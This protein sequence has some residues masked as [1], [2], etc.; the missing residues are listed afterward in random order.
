MQHNIGHKKFNIYTMALGYH[1]DDDLINEYNET[2]CA[3]TGIWH[4]VLLDEENLLEGNDVKSFIE[5]LKKFSK[6][7]SKCSNYKCIYAFDLGANIS[8]VLPEL[9]KELTF[10]ANIED[11]DINVFNIICS[12]S[13]SDVWDLKIKFHKGKNLIIFRDVAKILANP[14]LKD[15]A[16]ALN[17]DFKALEYD[18]HIN[19]R[20]EGFEPSKDDLNAIRQKA[21]LLLD[22]VMHHENDKYFFKSTSAASYSFRK[23]LDYAYKGSLKPYLE[24]RKEYPELDR[25]EHDF[26]LKSNEGGLTFVNEF[27]KGKEQA[28]VFHCDE[29]NAYPAKI[30]KCKLPYGK[31]IHKTKYIELDE[32]FNG[33]LFP[34]HYTICK[35]R[36]NV[37]YRLVPFR[38]TLGSDL[39]DVVVYC[40]DFEIP[41]LFK[42]YNYAE[43]AIED[44]YIYKTKFSRFGGYFV[45]NYRQRLN[46]KSKG[47]N[48]GVMYF[49][50]LNN[51]FYGKQGEKAYNTIKIPQIDSLGNVYIVKEE[52]PLEQQKYLSTYT[53]IPM[54]SCISALQRCEM[55]KGIFTIGL[56]HYYYCDTDSHFTDISLE[57]MTYFKS[58]EHRD[59][60]GCWDNGEELE[61]AEFVG[62][63]RYKTLTKS[64]ETIIHNSGF[65]YE[66]GEVYKDVNLV[67]DIRTVN[68]KVRVIGGTIV[69]PVAK[70][71]TT[72]EDFENEMRNQAISHHRYLHKIQEQEA[73]N[74]ATQHL[75]W[76]LSKGYIT[77]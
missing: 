53:Y 67:N 34:G 32:N 12:D 18:T 77:R 71:I 20:V 26:A 4:W 21:Q 57:S 64:N 13:L 56:A 76:S 6:P 41:Y 30:V 66:N 17:F 40:W 5:N 55:M 50:I 65:T 38:R 44:M 22:V 63:K 58:L 51:S 42:C 29:H 73:I 46:A 60:I 61:R 8:F 14:K 62:E 2:G 69:V 47:D 45:D 1:N 75:R 25:D 52:L 74:D 16:K 59:F 54:F 3:T 31:P 23:A 35:C 10:K 70:S 39:M 9:L 49:K 11:D 27:Y 36:V 15:L 19:R 43:V 68:T 72:S 33:E 7:K 24:Y 48:Y 28:N 37:Q